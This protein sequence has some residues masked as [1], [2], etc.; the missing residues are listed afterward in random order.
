[1]KGVD[2]SRFPLKL[3]A[4]AVLTHRGS[5]AACAADWLSTVNMR[6]ASDAGASLDRDSNPRVWCEVSMAKV[7]LTFVQLLRERWILV[8]IQRRPL[9]HSSEIPAISRRSISFI[10]PFRTSTA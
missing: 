2:L 4:A 7:K 9:I 3:V 8:S 10:A 6:K 1:M 5:E